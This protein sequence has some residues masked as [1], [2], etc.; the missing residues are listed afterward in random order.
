MSIAGKIFGIGAN[1]YVAE[2]QFKEGEDPLTEEDIEASSQQVCLVSE[3]LINAIS[4]ISTLICT[5]ES[6][7]PFLRSF[8]WGSMCKMG[9][10]HK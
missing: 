1:Y 4:L 8:V 3:L 6:S 7:G 10:Y 2:A 9:H 5:K